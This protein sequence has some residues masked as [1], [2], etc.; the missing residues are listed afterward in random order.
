VSGSGSVADFSGY[1]KE[2]VA[3]TLAAY[4]VQPDRIL[5]DGELEAQV[6]SGGY[7]HRQ[8]YELVQNG[9]DAILESGSRGTVE[10]VLS[11]DTLY[12]A[13]QG[14]PVSDAGIRALLM[15]GLSSKRGEEIGRFGL[16]FK[17][18][19]AVCDQPEIFSSTVSLRF[20]PE[21]LRRELASILG[22]EAILPRLRTAVTLDVD[23]ERRDDPMLDDLLERGTTVIKLP[24]RSGKFSHL[25]SA[26]VEF[27]SEFV[28]F[29]P[30]VDRL[31]LS[32]VPQQWRRAI[33]TEPADHGFLVHDGDDVVHWQLLR[34]HVDVSSLPE[35]AIQDMDHRL[36]ERSRLPLVWAVPLE[37]GQRQRGQFWAFFPTQVQT[38]LQGIVNAPWKTNSD[39]ENLLDGPFN[40][41]LLTR[42]ANMI[43]AELPSLASANDPASFLDLLPARE[44]AGWAD[45]ALTGTLLGALRD[46]DCV[47]T[48]HGDSRRPEQTAFPP[49]PVKVEDLMP[50]LLEFRECEQEGIVHPSAEA[51]RDR[52]GR[53]RRL[54]CREVEVGAW[55]EGL[56]ADSSVR[57]SEAAI[58]LAEH[59]CDADPDRSRSVAQSKFV[60]VTT[61][62]LLPPN[63]KVLALRASSDSA[64]EHM[65]FVHPQVL[66][67]PGVREILEQ[68][69]GLGEADMEAALRG[70]VSSTPLGR[71]DWDEFW[72]LAASVDP[73]LVAGIVLKS[74]SATGRVQAKSLSGD[75]FELAEMLTI[76]PIVPDATQHP[77][78]KSVIDPDFQRDH[79]E[80]LEALGARGKPAKADYS[81]SVLFREYR[82]RAERRFRKACDQGRHSTPRAGYIEVR[83]PGE[84]GFVAPLDPLEELTGEPALLMSDALVEVGGWGGDWTVCHETRPDAYPRLK[85]ENPVRWVLENHGWV[86]TSLGPRRVSDCLSKEFSSVG[87][88][89]PV[90]EGG[91]DWEL[92]G[93]EVGRAAPTSEMWDQA[94]DRLSDQDL[95]LEQ[96]TEFYAL[97]ATLGIPCPDQIRAS[98]GE[99][100]EL[101]ATASVVVT[102]SRDDL[103]LA[104]AEGTNALY[105]SRPANSRVLQERWGLTQALRAEIAFEPFGEP[106]RLVDRFPGIVPESSDL[107]L[108]LTPCSSLWRER[109]DSNGG[110][111]RRAVDWAREG[112]TL[113][114]QQLT[115]GATP[116][117]ASELLGYLREEGLIDL[118]PE[119]FG[120][121]AQ[122]AE[123]RAVAARRADVA[124]RGSLPERLVAAVSSA[125][126]RAGI[127]ARHVRSHQLV[128]QGSE[129]DLAR[130][131]LAVYGIDVLRQ[132]RNEL[133]V[134]GLQPPSQWA[135]GS[136]ARTFVSD[137]GFPEAFAGFK[138]RGRDPW[139]DQ[140]GP[141]DLPLLH[142]FQSLMR[143][144]LVEF[145]AA[146]EPGRG[147][148]SLPTGSGKT[149]VATQ[150]LVEWLRRRAGGATILWI[151]GS[152]ELCEQ[153][154]ESWN[155]VW[156][157]LGPTDGRVRISRLWGP[158]N[159]RVVEAQSGTNIVVATFQS[160]ARRLLREEFDWVFAA[161]VVVID[162]A[163]TSV[164]PTFTK[165]LAR[166]G[167][168][169]VKTDRSLIGL[170]A[171]PFR[172]VG[173]ER[174][175]LRLAFRYGFKRFDLEM[176]E[177]DEAYR[178]LQAMGVLAHADHEVLRGESLELDE[179]ELRELT[180]FHK[181]PSSV[182]KAL[183]RVASRNERILNHVA[184]LPNDWPV[185]IF[186]ASVE[187]S[188]DLAVQLTMDGV[189]AVAITA[190]T[191]TGVRRDAIERFKQGDLRVLTNYG[192][193]TTGFDA[194]AVRAIYVTRP[195]FSPLLYQQM[196]GRG[197]RGPLNGGEERCLIVNVEDNVVE[198]G[199]S[200]AFRGF[201]H[202]W[203]PSGEP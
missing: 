134:N 172:G 161:D 102:S 56:C 164:A 109:R 40:R 83:P 75:Y 106:Y 122:D 51:T 132:Y 201:E 123:G 110:L 94:L 150:A 179:S 74:W 137:L 175:T 65:R 157:A 168:D 160:L 72:M 108:V 147:L 46:S 81:C 184:A 101:V 111:M 144:E 118:S 116:T 33:E 60:L 54:G 149:R 143:D 80:L 187:H 189:P 138:G 186:A 176:W 86:R 98:A 148:L 127:P 59:L 121:A 163:H 178:V 47:P 49:A 139:V 1:A 130:L 151:A 68:R 13:N 135:G 5:E 23:E 99:H 4:R 192:V 97:R 183:G 48:V 196:I 194:P 141:T 128:G 89:L 173:D 185:L 188:E 96:V 36:R 38:T 136:S 129:V 45:E 29:T 152:D 162:E 159:E 43:A 145:L 71:V 9:A 52:R 61:G 6:L 55:L 3:K 203:H 124:A 19:L 37:A 31:S 76:G 30:H 170:T 79:G 131:A 193:L 70:L 155:Q 156:R 177:R 7:G 26:L 22:E 198:F 15:S 39:R 114:Y 93:I 64:G 88:L 154:V 62:E 195:V 41:E 10:V 90:A 18:V 126:L 107:E 92:I 103:A 197:L 17:S 171:T 11:G 78:L 67:A 191:P 199:E 82:R 167:L 117:T 21:H 104:I 27:P 58:H 53:A 165:I 35:G 190:G 85:I 42:A 69:F 50:W 113:Y 28:V 112:D 158:A 84:R 202:L 100:L 32:V 166:L 77:D 24:L 200:L 57:G 63:S 181:L 87:A 140:L 66:S 34:Q 8:L 2:I 20:N 180:T 125:G 44:P 16:G 153:A 142:D 119:Q 91:S 12:C 174:E 115:S 169:R 182:E 95:T 146:D 105:T 120:S 14:A 73:R 25:E 133:A